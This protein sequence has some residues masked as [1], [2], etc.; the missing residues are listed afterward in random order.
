[1]LLRRHLR[2][3]LG[4]E[5]G[6]KDRD[7]AGKGDGQEEKELVEEENMLMCD[8]LWEEGV[9]DSVGRVGRCSR[10]WEGGR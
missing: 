9:E 2:E 10:E 5:S 6:E 3:I 8:T 1:M 7:Y 4:R